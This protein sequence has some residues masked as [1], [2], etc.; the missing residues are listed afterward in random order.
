[1]RTPP[2]RGPSHEPPL[3]GD[4]NAGVKPDARP[5][6]GADANAPVTPDASP[7]P[8]TVDIGPTP[9]T[10]IPP[11]T[12]PPDVDLLTGLALYLTLDDPNLSSTAR[13]DSGQRN[14]AV[15]RGFAERETA[16]VA[17]RNGGALKLTGGTTGGWIEVESSPSLNAIS[18]AFTVAVWLYRTP[19]NQSDGVIVARHAGGT[20]GC[21]Y[22]FSIRSATLHVGI[23]TGNGYFGDASGDRAVPATGW[24]HLAATYSQG[25][26]RLYMNGEPV[27]TATYALGLAPDRVP[28]TVGAIQDAAGNT[29]G[30]LTG[31]IDDLVLYSRML[32]AKEIAALA[33]GINPNVYRQIKGQ[34][35]APAVMTVRGASPSP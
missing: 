31:H 29:S 2:L 4:P 5:D 19:E 35:V 28:V 23:N 24:V 3:A 20:T 18:S 6:V 27:G 1:M 22:C 17:G 15:L 33:R 25:T 32:S 11:V 26:I 12:V 9:P 16:W 7:P 13:D 10:M 34:T 8:T 21:L 30:R 14:I